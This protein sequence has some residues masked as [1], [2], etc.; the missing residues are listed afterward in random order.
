METIVMLLNALSIFLREEELIFLLHRICPN[1]IVNL[2]VFSP[3][4]EESVVVDVKVMISHM[5][6]RQKL[7]VIFKKHKNTKYH[8][9]LFRTERSIHPVPVIVISLHHLVHEVLL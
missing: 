4:R 8:G 9:V 6:I 7:Q 2:R 3:F 5:I 1:I